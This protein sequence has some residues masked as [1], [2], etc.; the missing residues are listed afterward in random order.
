MSL[1][2]LRPIYVSLSIRHNRLNTT[3]YQDDANGVI[4]A[5]LTTNFNSPIIDKA[6]DFLC[7]VERMEI[8]LSGVPFYDASDFDNNRETLTI[9]SKVDGSTFDLILTKSAFTLSH[10]FEILSAYQYQDPYDNALF[11]LTF[12]INKDGII[13][14]SIIGGK[15]FS[16]IQ[17]EIPRRLNLILGI[18][19][20]RQLAATTNVESAYPRIDLGDDLDHIILVTNLP[21]NSDALGNVKNQ[22]LTDFSVPSSYSNSLAYGGNGQLIRQGFSTNLRQKVIYTPS[23]RRYLELLGDFPITNIMVEALYI[24]Q[25][26][27]Q[28]YV[29][30]PIGASFE[31]KIGFYLRQ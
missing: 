8:S 31:L 26:G 18:S 3:Y 2:R 27:V 10:L 12:S 20:N 22:V 6:S 19:L 11:N 23:E 4:R 7:A 15:T 25:D 14:I 24:N 29:P 28:K 21:T 16:D 1:A 9:R 17:I 30:L 5:R 13:I